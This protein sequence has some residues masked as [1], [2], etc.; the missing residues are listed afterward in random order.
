MGRIKRTN[1]VTNNPVKLPDAANKKKCTN[2]VSAIVGEGDDFTSVSSNNSNSNSNNSDKI[3]LEDKEYE[4]SLLHELSQAFKYNYQNELAVSLRKYIGTKE[5]EIQKIASTGYKSFVRSAHDIEDLKNEAIKQKNKLIGLNQQI[6][7]EGLNLLLQIQHKEEVEQTKRLT[8]LQ[9]SAIQIKVQITRLI[10]TAKQYN[11]ESKYYLGL[12]SILKGQQILNNKKNRNNSTLTM[13]EIKLEL[14]PALRDLIVKTKSILINGI[15][16]WNNNISKLT[17]RIGNVLIQG[18]YVHIGSHMLEEKDGRRGSNNGNINS[19]DP[20][21]ADATN[22]TNETNAKNETKD[23]ANKTN[24]HRQQHIDNDNDDNIS[25]DLTPIKQFFY[26][27]ELLNATNEAQ[28]IYQ[29]MRMPELRETCLE[30]ALHSNTT[31]SSTDK[32]SPLEL[33]ML[34]NES[35]RGKIS[36]VCQRLSAVYFV[37]DIVHQR[38]SSLLMPLDLLCRRWD[39]SIK[40][41]LTQWA[42]VITGVSG[43]RNE[44]ENNDNE[45]YSNRSSNSNNSNNSNR[46]DIG[47]IDVASCDPKL[48]TNID[49]S[50]LGLYFCASRMSF[51]SGPIGQA[52]CVLLYRSVTSK[53]HIDLLLSHITSSMNI[54]IKEALQKP[55]K[56]FKRKYNILNIETFQTLIV[57]YGLQRTSS[58]IDITSSDIPCNMAFSTIVP[59]LCHFI[60]MGIEQCKRHGALVLS[61]STGTSTTGTGTGTGSNTGTGTGSN[62]GSNSS[63]GGGNSNNISIV[64][65]FGGSHHIGTEHT[66]KMHSKS[67]CVVE[68]G[69]NHIYK[70]LKHIISSMDEHVSHTNH[71]DQEDLFEKTSSSLRSSVTSTSTTSSSSSTSSNPLSIKTIRLLCQITSDT[72]ALAHG[73]RAFGQELLLKSLNQEDSSSLLRLNK[74]EQNLVGLSIDAQVRMHEDLTKHI[75]TLMTTLL[76]YTN[77]WTASAVRE[78]GRPGMVI[79]IE[80]LMVLFSF[81][82][83]LSKEHRHLTHM[84]AMRHICYRMI[85]EIENVASGDRK[86]HRITIPSIC[87]FSSDILLLEQYASECNVSN[88]KEVFAEPRQLCNLLLSGHIDTILDEAKRREYYPSVSINLLVRI[89]TR[90]KNVNKK[91][92]SKLQSM[93]TRLFSST[94]S[95]SAS[96]SSDTSADQESELEHDVV[97]LPVLPPPMTEKQA[98]ALAL[99]IESKLLSSGVGKI[100]KTYAV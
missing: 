87:N 11:N 79:L 31:S 28:D 45:D 53:D 30:F 76:N 33:A 71:T 73:C 94:A 21:E 6:N 78:K 42:Q 27:F 98:E 95:A 64:P 48:L 60:Q 43:N 22:E 93:M 32:L 36:K 2:A 29:K 88:L 70:R 5:D 65:C 49:T 16:E 67:L 14:V 4:K 23:T 55:K 100:G 40:N 96:T 50:T 10:N 61:K 7:T 25:I 58:G 35:M 44:N 18:K 99:R 89:L 3:I 84:V 8:A 92:E 37:E 82:N 97:V 41:F 72:I 56:A 69:F 34:H 74:I 57:P 68:H 80:E 46:N 12:Q 77:E 38:V 63:S 39:E 20:L 13:K 86:H 75:D 26:C 47:R 83:D 52:R 9:K 66:M 90:F 19:S 62:T 51:L 59:L 24:H 15:Q 81:S 91:G 17:N 1:T 85:T 54:K